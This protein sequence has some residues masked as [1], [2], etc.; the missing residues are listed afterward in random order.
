MKL[1]ILA[2]GAHPDDVELG[3]GGT[4]LS[5]VAKGH[6]VGIV[7]LTKGEL[8]T[9]GTAE[10][11]MKEAE[12]SS[13]I[14]GIISRENLGFRDGFFMKDETHL[15]RV[16]EMIRKYQPEI[17]MCNTQIDR[18][19][20]HGKGADLVHEACF[21]SG[22]R[23]IETSLDGIEQQAWRPKNVYHY[24]QDYY[25][26]PDVIIDITPFM[27]KKL[28]SIMAYGT[29]FYNPNAQ[30]PATAISGKDFIDFIEARARDYGRLIG[31]EFGE[32][33]TTKRPIGTDDLFHLR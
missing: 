33:F 14:L 29:Q 7:D 1:D 15:I 19:T 2:F 12:A 25:L 3:A 20:D 26:K 21:L 13:K 11:R 31:V 17:V 18:H 27:E 28:Q 32:G 9:R 4:V 8:G 5:H 16:I 30:E 10:T 23:K 6:K 24:V 22:L